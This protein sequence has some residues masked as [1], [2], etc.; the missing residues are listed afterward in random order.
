[1]KFSISHEGYEYMHTVH[2][3]YDWKFVK[4][5][6]IWDFYRKIRPVLTPRVVNLE[7]V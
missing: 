3:A 4:Y 7:Q 6:Y 5:L 1:M 2:K